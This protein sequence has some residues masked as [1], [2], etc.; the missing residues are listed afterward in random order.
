[1]LILKKKTKISLRLYL[2]KSEK[3]QKGK[4]EKAEK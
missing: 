2:K 3:E 1:M 4:P